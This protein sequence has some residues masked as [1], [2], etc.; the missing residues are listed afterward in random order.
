MTLIRYHSIITIMNVTR[1]VFLIIVMI[2]LNIVTW[3]I[4]GIMPSAAYLSNILTE[5][6]IDICGISEH[7]LLPD[8]VHFMDTLFNDYNH[9]TVCCNV[10]HSLSS[11]VRGKGGVSIIW[12]KKYNSMITPLSIDSDC[13]CGIQMQL[14]P[15]K[16]IY[17]F[18]V[19]LPCVNHSNEKY[20][21]SLSCLYDI[22]NMYCDQG[23]TI[24]LGDFNA[25][26]KTAIGSYRKRLLCQF[27][28]DCNL[29]AVNM[30]SSCVGPHNSYVSYDD[31]YTSL[32][33]YVFIPI[34]LFDSV[35]HC[36]VADDACLNI[37]R[38]RPI[39]FCIDILMHVDKPIDIMKCSINW[40]SVNNNHILQYCNLLGEALLSTDLNGSM[41]ASELYSVLCENMRSCAKDCFPR[42]RYKRHLKPFW[43]DELASFHGQMDTARDEWC[44]AGRPR[45]DQHL[46]YK[47]YK[48]AKSHFRR[49]MRRCAYVF[50]AELDTKL[51]HDCKHDTV[52]FWRTVN[53]RKRGSGANIGGGMKFDGQVYRS[54]EDIVAQWSKYFKNLYTPSDSPSFDAQWENV[55]R[56]TVEESFCKLSP[57]PDTAVAPE[58]VKECIKNL[59]KGKASGPDDIRHEH[60]LYSKDVIAEPLAQLYTIMLQSGS[61][62]DSMKTG[63][64]ITLFKGGRKRRDDPNSYRA[65]TLS[66][67][68][69]KL[70]ETILLN[71]CKDNILASI[72]RLQGGFQDGLGCIM[73]SF[74]LRECLYYAKELG[75]R[76]YICFLD[77]RQAF[78]R[79][80]HDGLFYKL[81][82]TS[83]TD[84]HNPAIDANTLLAFRDMYRNAT[85]RVRH[86]GLL[87]EPLPV[88]QGTRQGGKSSPLLYLVYVNGLIEELESSGNGTCLY[89]INMAAPTVADDMV[90]LSYSKNGLD[91]MLQICT[92][93]ANKW[94]FLYNASKCSVLIYNNHTSE[95]PVFYLGQESIPISDNYI[96]LGIECNP[97]LSTAKNIDDACIRLRGS[98]MGL[99]AKGI[100]PERL[101]PS[102]LMTVFN[103][104]ILPKALYGCE[105]WN[106]NSATDL[107]RLSTAQKFCLKNMQGYNRHISSDFCLL[108]VN[109]IPVVNTLE[110]RKLNLFG[111]ICRLNPNYLAKDV[112][113]NRLV[114][115][116]NIDRQCIGFIPDVYKLLQKYDLLAYLQAYLEDGQFPPRRQWKSIVGRSVERRARD[117][118][119]RRLQA[120]DQWGVTVN[121]IERDNC[122]PLWRVAKDNPRLLGMCK[123]ILNSIGNI[124]SRQFLQVCELCNFHTDNLTVH[125]MC[126]CHVLERRRRCVWTCL[127]GC[128][129]ATKYGS[130][131][132]LNDFEQCAYLFRLVTELND[133]QFVYFALCKAVVK[134]L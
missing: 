126:H 57:N 109:A 83:G 60:L 82:T 21:D 43:T 54:R 67:T 84:A 116:V 76:V 96:H 41:N 2:A 5:G 133:L 122:S 119:T 62:P 16:Y 66:S 124:V 45:G 93:Y 51:E 9:Y 47:H 128:V 20:Y 25:D 23:E 85:S 91:N 106:N 89:D 13:I 63:E 131:T 58:V 80:W 130:F 19:Y 98:Y 64:I 97:Y 127:Y 42:K 74:C 34:E 125:K 10:E 115:Y 50:M 49:H 90:L 111:Q 118:L 48:E 59:P 38:H 102:T 61:I 22:Y 55:V 17:V 28:A 15:G 33:D 36:E 121:V 78:D 11:R 71:R 1:S 26:I 30:H 52:S 70:Y 8:N 27:V 94:R 31:R 35:N 7:W 107:A 129:G 18:Q 104:A 77:A 73:T 92:N 81:L 69:L 100:S 134:V 24:F 32:I 105:L 103:S 29:F 114:R 117:D 37:S 4:T 113:N 95:T 99:C 101:S 3:N 40:K 72:K 44:R 112:F 75:S 46:E 68:L 120:S 123:T 12:K 87:S 65:I 132:Q 53:S 56:Q 88:R 110:S 108:T 39:V 6:N 86:Q 14:A 79:V